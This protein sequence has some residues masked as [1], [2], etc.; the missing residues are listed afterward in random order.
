MKTGVYLT[1]GGIINPAALNNEIIPSQQN[2]GS[3]PS[4]Y[5]AVT[6]NTADNLAVAVS[7]TNRQLRAGLSVLPDE[8]QSAATAALRANA[9]VVTEKSF[10]KS[11]FTV[12]SSEWT[13]AGGTAFSIGV[14]SGDD[15]QDLIKP[16]Q[17]S[18]SA[19]NL[20][21][22]VEDAVIEPGGP[23]EGEHLIVLIDQNSGGFFVLKFGSVEDEAAALAEFGGTIGYDQ[24]VSTGSTARQK[25]E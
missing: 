8:A 12:A 4:L 9:D 21:G 7:L 15:Y 22:L 13:M 5:T 19:A 11:D 10:L 2:T 6:K 16:V 20:L 23:L 14:G 1:G 17:P 18:L 3:L 25:F 24:F